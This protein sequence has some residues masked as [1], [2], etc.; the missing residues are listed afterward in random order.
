MRAHPYITDSEQTARGDVDGVV[1]DH[2]NAASSLLLSFVGGPDSRVPG[3]MRKFLVEYY[4][5]TA[6][7]AMISIDPAHVTQRMLVPD[8]V[9]AAH[10]LLTEKYIGHLCGCW[11]QLLLL[12]PQIF[13]LGSRAYAP[14]V[15]T[16]PTFP[17]SDD[18]MTFCAL[19]AHITSFYPTEDTHADV[20]LAGLIYQK[21]VLLYLYTTLDTLP[22]AS[23]GRGLYEGLIRTTVREAMELLAAL[24]PVARINTSLCWPIAVIGAVLSDTAE[25]MILRDRLQTM[26]EHIG[27]GNIDATA[28]LLDQMWMQTKEERNPWTICKTMQEHQLWISFA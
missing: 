14:P 22:R 21:A 5:Y 4:V 27:L 7:L 1:F 8:L 28:R 16:E 17:S 3:E 13:E 25:Q 9:A 18:F 24:S 2:L 11:L 26:F 10:Q 15:A 20:K 6:T 19:Q 12:I 23:S